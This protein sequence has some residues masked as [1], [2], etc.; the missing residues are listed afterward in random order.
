MSQQRRTIVLGVAMAAILVALGVTPLMSSAAKT[1]AATASPETALTIVNNSSREIRHVFFSAT[2]DDNW[3]P[4]QLNNS[5]IVVGGS[6]TLNVSCS[7]STIKVIA[8][9]EDGCFFY[10]VVSCS[11]SSSWTIDSSSTRDCGN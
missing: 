7:S 11:E 5:A 2:T 8:E 3:G 10:Q 4:D 9:D 1:E 6:R